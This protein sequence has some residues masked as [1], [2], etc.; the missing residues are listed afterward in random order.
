MSTITPT[1]A[2]A[3]HDRSAPPTRDA[4]RRRLLEGLGFVAVWV[5]LGYLV[6]P[7][8]LTYLLLGVPLTIG[9][10]TLVRRRPLR[11]LWVRDATRFTLDK[12]GLVL[13]AV[14]V[15]APLYYGIQALPG[16][17]WWLTGWYIAATVGAVGAAFAL[18]ATTPV[19]MLR[20]AL[21]PM[22]VGAG[23]MAAVLGGIHIVTGTPVH[24]LVVLGTVTK[25]LAVYFPLTFIIE[26][27]AFRGALDAHVHHGGEGRGWLSAAFVSALWGLWHLPISTGMA[28]PLLVVELLAVHI[29][30]GVP[31]SFAW[32]RSGNL[33]GPAF[34]HAAIDAVRNALIL[35]L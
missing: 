31:L 3:A 25:Y 16:A 2:S 7:N 33:A 29:L 12:R 6:C 27:V 22:T 28:F 5:A 23:G 13:A 4:R 26:E 20:S 17:H 15:A 21:L 30:I 10:Q 18:R 9:F 8:D 11:A 34:A 1:A 24:V 32:R 19:A 35:G 14:L